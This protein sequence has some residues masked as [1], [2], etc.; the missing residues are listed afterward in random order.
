M[1]FRIQTFGLALLASTLTF[2][3]AAA[4]NQPANGQNQ[5]QNQGGADERTRGRRD[6]ITRYVTATNQLADMLAKLSEEA[7]GGD[8]KQR[9]ENAI[10]RV[11]QIKKTLKSDRMENS[12][13]VQELL[14][15][16]HAEVAQASGKLAA[17][18][19]RLKS[20]PEVNPEL[21]AL[22]EKL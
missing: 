4:Q 22:L 11:A 18:V 5:N 10:E 9:L 15:E 2:Q 13:Q 3:P 17:Q 8:V 1:K 19:S 20:A 6:I 21:L 7:A 12:P 14:K 16:K